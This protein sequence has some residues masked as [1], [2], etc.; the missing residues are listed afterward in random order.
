MTT[1]ARQFILDIVICN[2]FGMYLGVEVGRYLEIS[3]YNWT[4]FKAIETVQ[5]KVR[6]ATTICSLVAVGGGGVF[7][8]N[9]CSVFRYACQGGG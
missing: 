9:L 1:R 2:G 6:T 8:G 3:Q 4:G 5:G 7:R